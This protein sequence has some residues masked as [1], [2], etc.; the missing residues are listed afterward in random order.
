MKKQ[1]LPEQLPPE[2][3]SL[4]RLLSILRGPGGCPWDRLQTHQRLIPY[5]REE[6]RE[7]IQAIQ[8]RVPDEL[9]EELGDLL[10]QIVFHIQIAEEKGE[11]TAQEVFQGIISKLY[12]RHPHVFGKKRLTTP[13]AVSREWQRIKAR[14]KIQKRR[15]SLFHQ[16]P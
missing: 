9:C 1:I 5:L 11:F 16:R 2:W 3:T 13:R 6:T 15:K 10:L 8:Q 4:R 7:V 14:E 12:R